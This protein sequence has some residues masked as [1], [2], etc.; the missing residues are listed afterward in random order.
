MYDEH[1]PLKVGPLTSTSS[2]VSLGHRLSDCSNP[3]SC[4]TEPPGNH[5]VRA[6]ISST[7]LCV[8]QMRARKIHGAGF[9]HAVDE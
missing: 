2:M 5:G 7:S 8:K 6:R 9:G 4:V 1:L 3:E